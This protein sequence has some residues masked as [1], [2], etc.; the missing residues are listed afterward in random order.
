MI[1][2]KADLSISRVLSWE[3]VNIHS[4]PNCIDSRRAPEKEKDIETRIQGD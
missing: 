2:N 3:Q 4:K 1:G